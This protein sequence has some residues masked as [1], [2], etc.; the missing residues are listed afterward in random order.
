MIPLQSCV[1]EYPQRSFD[2]IVRHEQLH[3]CH[4][5]FHAHADTDDDTEIQPVQP[6][7]WVINQPTTMRL[8]KYALAF[9]V[10]HRFTRSLNQDSFRRSLSDAFGLD[11]GA[12]IGLEL[13]FA[14]FRGAQVGVYRTKSIK[15]N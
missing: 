8:P 9:R 13:R 2:V 10:T 11:S 6:D 1:F 14:P 5:A 15:I 4:S 3:A 12:M 7:F